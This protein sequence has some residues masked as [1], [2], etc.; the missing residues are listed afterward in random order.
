MAATVSQGHGAPGLVNSSD[1]WG[2]TWEWPLKGGVFNSGMVEVEH[3][4]E[5]REGEELE[6]S[7][8]SSL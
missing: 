4:S 5:E 6:M 2:A 1:R 7:D 3:A 8:K